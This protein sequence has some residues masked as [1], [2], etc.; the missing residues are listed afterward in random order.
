MAPGR[1]K[2]REEDDVD[3]PEL[4]I[5]GIDVEA[6]MAKST[7]SALDTR[8]VPTHVPREVSS[9]RRLLAACL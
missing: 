4:D 3:V 1:R 7:V 6:I 2:S 8:A 5:P 9:A